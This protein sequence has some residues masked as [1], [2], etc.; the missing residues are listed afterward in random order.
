MELVKDGRLTNLIKEK[1]D[2][3]GR[4]SDKEAS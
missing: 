2:K 1:F 4:F 3:Q